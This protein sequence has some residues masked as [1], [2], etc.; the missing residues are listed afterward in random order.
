MSMVREK[1]LSMENGGRILH[2][3]RD[4]IWQ[5][6]GFVVGVVAIGVSIFVAY[7]VFVLEQERHEVTATVLA[8][9]SD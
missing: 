4:N 5:F 9:D 1:T 7:H 8:S 6:F 3:L 2:L